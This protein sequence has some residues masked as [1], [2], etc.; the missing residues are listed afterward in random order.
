M[1]MLAKFNP[2]PGELLNGVVFDGHW[3]VSHYLKVYPHEFLN[4]KLNYKFSP[5]ATFH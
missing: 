3:P 5:K 4:D 2:V 1:G